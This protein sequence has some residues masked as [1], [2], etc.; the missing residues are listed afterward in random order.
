M[1]SSREALIAWAAETRPWPEEARLGKSSDQPSANKRRRPQQHEE[2]HSGKK[3]IIQALRE[4]V[5]AENMQNQPEQNGK[6]R[7]TRP[8]AEKRDELREMVQR[9]VQE[10]VKHRL[11]FS[12]TDNE[13][14]TKT[15]LTNTLRTVMVLCTTKQEKR[16]TEL[17]VRRQAERVCELNVGLFLEDHGRENRD[18]ANSVVSSAVSNEDTHSRKKRFRALSWTPQY[19][20]PSIAPVPNR[21]RHAPPSSAQLV[22]QKEPAPNFDPSTAIGDDAF[23]TPQI[24]KRPN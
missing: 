7:P 23:F 2:E 22:N 9:V 10:V 20:T 13:V 16:P 4:R 17:D 14:L 11:T 12:G 8:V 5:L 15:I 24:T 6:A 21:P 1:S 19:E 3:T 18:D